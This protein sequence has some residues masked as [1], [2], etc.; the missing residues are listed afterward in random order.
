MISVNKDE[1]L[2]QEHLERL[3]VFPLPSAVLFPNTVLPLHVFE[4]RYRELT[5]YC[6]EHAWPMA[7]PGIVESVNEAVENPE[8]LEIAGAGRIIHH[9]EMPDGRFLILLQGVGRVRIVSEHTTDTAYRVV[10][11]ELVP[12]QLGN[13]DQLDAD[14]RTIRDCLTLLRARVPNLVDALSTQASDLA[15]AALADTLGGILFKSPT[16]RQSLLEESDV[17]KRVRVVRDRV[18]ALA[19]RTASA[20]DP[21]N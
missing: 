18:A 13:T 20:D 17:A 4:P 16:Q 5:R 14:V 19:A 6:L 15:P 12:N 8:L 11:A 7:I 3:P 9:Q 21:V 2:S 10:K 1:G